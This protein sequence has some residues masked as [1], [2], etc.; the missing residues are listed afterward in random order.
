MAESDNLLMLADMAKLDEEERPLWDFP[1]ETAPAPSQVDTYDHC[2]L[3]SNDVERFV[4]STHDYYYRVGQW[5]LDDQ[6]HSYA[7]QVPSGSGE[8]DLTGYEDSGTFGPSASDVHGVVL[9][10][11]RCQWENC[12]L[13]FENLEDLHKHAEG[14]LSATSRTCMWRGCNKS[15]RRYAHRYLLCRHLRS[16]T[17]STP[18]A[19]EHCG[20]QFATKERMRLHVRAIH[21]PEV[22]YMCD[23]CDRLFKT[24]AERRH[25]ITRTHMQERLMCCFCAGLYSGRTAL[26]RHLK[27]CKN[28]HTKAS[29][30]I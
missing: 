27:T 16:H 14:H 25:H 28:K 11:H 6:E 20:T 12:S 21:A 23:V 26:N 7:F 19:C 18:F 4:N 29:A 2:Y 3:R 15:N 5:D 22:K 8:S 10:S 1:V 17:G 24:T 9:N 13:G 30:P